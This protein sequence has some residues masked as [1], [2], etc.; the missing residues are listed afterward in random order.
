MVSS[1][2]MMECSDVGLTCME[3]KQEK[4]LSAHCE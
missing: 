4:I 1:D 3:V 2:E